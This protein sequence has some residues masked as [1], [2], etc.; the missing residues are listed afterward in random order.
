[1]PV[2]R[3]ANWTNTEQLAYKAPKLVN[4]RLAESKMIKPRYVQR[5]MPNKYSC[6]Q[7]P[8]PNIF[9]AYLHVQKQ[10][11]Q[12]TISQLY[13]STLSPQK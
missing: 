13:Q 5:H 9:H 8:K 12:S 4:S 11:Y 3:A 6:Q 2:T 7:N 1:M 10:L